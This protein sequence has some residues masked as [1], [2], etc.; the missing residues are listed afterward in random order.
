MALMKDVAELAG[1]SVTTVSFVL[2][3][4][5]KKYKVADKTAKK[6]LQAAKQ[7]NYRIN[8]SVSD[9]DAI[10]KRQPTIVFLVPME[11]AW[12][13]MNVIYSSVKKHIQQMGRHYNVLLSPYERGLLSDKIEQL[14]LSDYDAAVISI[15]CNGDMKYLEENSLNIPVVLY[16]C[17]SA[18]YSGVLSMSDEAITQAVNMIVAKKYSKIV[19]LS[20]NDSKEYRDD[21]LN[22]LIKICSDNGIELS[23]D[24]FITTENTMIGGAIAARNILNSG[25]RP[26]LII[27]MSTNLAFGAIPLLARNQILIPRDSELLCFGSSGDVEHIANYI[28][29]LSVIAQ[30]IDELTIKAFDIAIHLADGKDEKSIHYKY[31]CSLLLHSSFSL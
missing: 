15:A 3:G 9:M 20:G 29:S 24:D 30:P 11:S 28:P 12:I 1:V 21:H 25:T 17:L 14:Q 19:I 18:K 31:P 16:D 22:T 26:E 13:D 23:E 4:T 8:T 7:L 10:T 6:I 5:A 27:C 2:N